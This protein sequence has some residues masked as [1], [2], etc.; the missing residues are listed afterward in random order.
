ML[1][2]FKRL[3]NQSAIYGLS[4]VMNAVIGFVLVPIYARYLTP[5]DYG[6]LTILTITANFAS[7]FLQLSIGTAIFRSVIQRDVNRQVVLSTAFYFLLTMVIVCLG[8]LLFFST[9]I[10]EV[11]FSEASLIASTLLQLALITVTLGCCY[12]YYIGKTTN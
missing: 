5:A 4:G 2:Q 3:A 11:L 12:Y 1:E 9:K 6:I 8:S 10:S 7:V